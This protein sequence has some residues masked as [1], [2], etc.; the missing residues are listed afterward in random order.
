LTLSGDYGA[1]IASYKRA[2]ALY[3]T[4]DRAL[5]SVEHKLGSVHHRHGEWEQAENHFRNALAR[6][7]KHGQTETTARIYAD[8][9]LTAH[10]QGQTSQ[11]LFLATK[12]L[13]LTAGD[14][15]ALAQVYRISSLSGLR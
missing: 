10:H 2:A 14:Q 5:A 1:A 8:W 11:A 3:E 6:Q 4:D 9:S 12:A 7:E 15:R 13:E